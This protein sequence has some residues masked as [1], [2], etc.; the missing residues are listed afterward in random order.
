ML[1]VGDGGEGSG[2]FENERKRPQGGKKSATIKW[3]KYSIN[4]N[5][6]TS[7]Y[8]MAFFQRI[9]GDVFFFK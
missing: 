5:K 6:I 3:Q 9:H 4:S 8:I 1:L 7:I 2:L